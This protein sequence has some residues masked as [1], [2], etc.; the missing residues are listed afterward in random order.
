MKPPLNSAEDH[1]WRA[2]FGG[3]GGAGWKI[4]AVEVEV[5]EREKNIVFYPIYHLEEGRKSSGKHKTK[6]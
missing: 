1:R 5:A 2:V 3:V 6:L 4:R